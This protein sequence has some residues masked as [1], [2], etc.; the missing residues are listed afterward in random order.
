MPASIPLVQCTPDRNGF[1]RH[2]DRSW[3]ATH[4]AYRSSP[5]SHHA[6]ASS[7]RWWCRDSSQIC[8]TLPV[9]V[10]S[11]C[12]TRNASPVWGARRPVIGSRNQSGAALSGRRTPKTSHSPARTRS[13]AR[14]VAAAATGS[15]PT[16]SASG[17]TARKVR[18]RRSPPAAGRPPRGGPAEG[19]QARRRTS[20]SARQP[21][22]AGDIRRSRRRY[23]PRRGRS[24][25]HRFASRQA[26]P[27]GERRP[28]RRH[29]RVH[30]DRHRTAGADRLDEGSELGP[31]A[32]VDARH[33]PAAACVPARATP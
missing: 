21:T 31:L 5:V 23:Q 1:S 20:S 17:R 24:Q 26:L 33:R 10:S 32:L 9:T 12:G 22:S 18:S 14:T 27:D 19:A 15:T 16:T 4:S 13:A 29:E 30:G 7:V 6:A 28:R 11:R 25:C 3:S 8:L 2:Q